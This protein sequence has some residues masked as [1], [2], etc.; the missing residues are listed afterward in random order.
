MITHRHHCLC[1]LFDCFDED[2]SGKLEFAE[3]LNS[4]LL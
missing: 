4:M 2:K 3:F 1:C